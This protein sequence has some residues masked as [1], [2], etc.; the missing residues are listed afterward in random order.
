M[1]R[2]GGHFFPVT[3]VEEFVTVLNG[4]AARIG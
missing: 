4:F 1:F 2:T 3:R